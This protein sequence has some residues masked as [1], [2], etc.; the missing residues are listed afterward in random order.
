[1]GFE[2][3]TFEKKD[4]VATITLNEPPSNWLTILMMKEINRVLLDVKMDPTV[5]LLVFDAAGGKAFCD[6]V[7][8]A[9]H[10]PD[11]VDEMIFVFHEMFRI[12]AS[13]DVTTV[14]LV[15]G[16][17]LGGGCELMAF[18]DI[19]I[20]SEKA[21]IGQPEIAV[22]VFPPVAAAWFPKI[23]GL[24]KTMELLLTG[25][26]ISAKEAE[27]IGLV[28]VVLPA[29][30]FKEGVDKFLADFLNK[31]RPVAMWT[32]RAIM[33]GLNLDFIGALK[34]SE[35][36]YLQGCM[37]TDDAKEGISAFMEKRKAV[38]KDK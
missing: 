26:I 27:A 23:I 30:N 1:M 16:R 15:N 19:V 36:L 9:D 18:C 20:A 32:R 2:H 21:K 35:I 24:K 22:G 25:K 5:Q 29:E 6:G 12:M 28:N 37:A 7:D 14:A 33:A 4:K 31:S 3:I 13:L 8:V 11:K 34:A 10:T 38:F 17:S